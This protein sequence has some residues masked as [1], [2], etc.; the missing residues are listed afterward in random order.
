MINFS[1]QKCSVYRSTFVTQS[2]EHQSSAA[3]M[4]KHTNCA[5]KGIR[6]GRKREKGGKNAGSNRKKIKK[7]KKCLMLDSR[8]KYPTLPSFWLHFSKPLA[9]LRLYKNS[10]VYLSDARITIFCKVQELR[11]P[12]SY[13][14]H[15]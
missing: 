7:K 10:A 9:V 12:T 8:G 2:R 11:N 1:H 14:A 15:Q 4:A 13:Y 3:Q 6:K 5:R